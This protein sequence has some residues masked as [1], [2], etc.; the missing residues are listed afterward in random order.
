MSESLR[1]MFP[2][3]AI[4]DDSAKDD[5]GASADGNPVVLS[6]MD[7]DAAFIEFRRMYRRAK[8][9]SSEWRKNA[10][11]DYA[12]V[13]NDQWSPEDLAALRT[14]MRPTITFNRIG[15]AVDTVCGMEVS[16]R[17]MVQY[18]PREE[19]D[20]RVNELATGAAE[21]VRENCDAEDEESDAFYDVTVCGVGCTRTGLDYRDD[22]DGEIKVERIDPLEMY[23]DPGATKR[24]LSDS[25]YFFRVRELTRDAAR[26]LF[27]DEDIDDLHAEWTSGIY[28]PQE[29]H[30]AT[31]AKFYAHDQSGRTGDLQRMIRMV[32][33]EWWEPYTHYRVADPRNGQKLFLASDKWGELTKRFQ[34]N[35]LRPPPS[36]KQTKRQWFR[37]FIGKKVLDKIEPAPIKDSSSYKFITGKRDRNARSWYGIVRPMKDPQRWAN[38]WMSQGLYVL[39]TN[40]KGGVM[41][42]D[43]AVKDIRKFEQDWTKPDA[44]VEL[45][46]GGIGRIQER[47]DRPFPQG[48]DRLTT[49]AVEAIWQVTGL[50]PEIQGNAN[51]DQPGVLEYQ[52]KQAG[53]NILAPIFDSYRRYRKEQGRL[54]FEMIREYISDGRLV[55]IVG[56]QKARYVPLIKQP[57]AL[58]YDVIVDDTPTSPNQKELTWQVLQPLLPIL[59]EKAPPQ[60]LM[61]V[62]KFTPLPAS[63]VDKIVQTMQSIPQ[64]PDPKQIEMQI[65][66]MKAQSDQQIAQI[67][68]QGKQA[69]AEAS[70]AQA[71]QEMASSKLEFAQKISTLQ[72]ELEQMK[73]KVELDRSN[74]LLNLTKAGMAV[75][76]Q[77]L[78]E[79][80]LGLDALLG[81]HDAAMAQH[82]AEMDRQSA[83]NERQKTAIAGQSAAVQDHVALNPVSPP[84]DPNKEAATQAKAKGAAGKKVQAVND[85][86]KGISQSIG[87]LA[88]M[89][90]QSVDRLAKLHEQSMASQA[91]MLAEMR[92]EKPK[93]KFNVIRDAK[94]GRVIGAEEG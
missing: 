67:N 21:W 59:I 19:G 49:M 82:G 71:Q 88:D 36:L 91:E 56:Q 31:E 23:W 62:L 37:A 1:S 8:E 14:Q 85:S 52:R 25:G 10:R 50:N 68:M 86:V 84:I 64:Q 29:P 60:V 2:P 12:F 47:T 51:R 46:P 69:E 79:A 6:R 66:Q 70:A 44:V 18:K 5:R 90:K 4:V 76:A 73:A 55:R 35:G 48:F 58:E 16:N 39:N 65:A 42:E 57:G 75:R 32:E 92:K 30:D 11:E 74:A 89:H 80:E 40:A 61:E 20:E 83:D 17:Q 7:N 22:P 53:M 15:P 41:V 78:A 93:R 63:S 94:T 28:M 26:M 24:N 54:L 87:K 13:A 45:N 38:K 72:L 34:A 77:D 33:V 43:G 81:G 3:P 27:P 9:G